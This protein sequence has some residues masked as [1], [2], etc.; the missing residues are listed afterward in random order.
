MKA[1]LG[2]SPGQDKMKMLVLVVCSLCCI[3]GL[4]D[5]VAAAVHNE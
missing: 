2:L 3:L 4:C 5:A 1:G